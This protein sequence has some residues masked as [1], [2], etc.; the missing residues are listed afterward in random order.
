MG[1]KRRRRSTV[2]G[3]HIAVGQSSE[4]R[5]DEKVANTEIRSDG[6][7]LAVLSHS[8]GIQLKS[9]FHCKAVPC[10]AV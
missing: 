2:F 5:T 9:I 7:E 8:I 1:A 3:E 6:D 10:S 4:K